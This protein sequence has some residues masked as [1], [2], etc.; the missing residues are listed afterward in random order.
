[1]PD[2]PDVSLVTVTWN[3]ASVIEQF[4]DSLAAGCGRLACELIV[5]D[6]AS[7]D[8]T[9]EIARSKMPDAKVIANADNRGLAAANNQGLALARAPLIAISNPDVVFHPGA[10]ESM[11]ATL[12]RRPRAGWVVPRMLYESGA[13]HTSAGRLPTLADAILGRIVA[14]WLSRNRESLWMDGWAHDEE[15]EIERGHEAFYMV[16]REAVDEVGGQDERFV[17][18]WEGPDW[19]DRFRRS[20]WEIWL[21][22]DAEV[23][24]LGG[25][26]IRQ[27]PLRWI[28]STHRGM[29]YYFS[30]RRPA[31]W[32]PVL[33]AVFAT[34][35]LLKA[36]MAMARLPMYEWAHRG[37]GRA[38]QRRSSR[39]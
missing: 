35:G 16:R 10:L 6:N 14:R 7:S 12:A 21:C 5:V 34:R 36:A 20:G 19:M 28:M 26:S 18:D 4:L 15:R 39:A 23:V 31:G 22:P 30:D 1:M 27:V 33:A 13:V 17:L 11:A 3:S 25:A 29:Y 37:V 32:K 24:H 8:S 9:V 38:D 2:T